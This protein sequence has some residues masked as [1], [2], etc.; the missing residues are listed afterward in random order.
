MVR[1]EVGRRL[2]MTQAQEQAFYEAHKQEFEQPEQ[3]RLS[4]ILIPTPADADGCCGGAGAGEGSTILRRR[5]RA[6]RSSTSWRR[7]YSGGP[8]AAAGRRPGTLQAWRA[9]Q[10]S[11]RPDVLLKAGETTAPIRTRQ[12]FV[13]LKVTEHQAAGVPAL[14][15]I[16]P[17]IQEA[18]YTEQ[19]QPAMRA[20]LTSLR[21][22][23]Y[24]DIKSGFVDTGASPKQTKPVFTAIRLR[25]EEEDS[26]GEAA[27]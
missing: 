14:K 9:G 27:V 25:G 1:E 4:E 26:R 18:L 10:G 15:D 22:D 11:G 20:Y 21:E 16:E 2:Q 6:A 23:A 3:V 19:L 7:S 13:I 8:T 24:I 5:L 12:G 17:Q